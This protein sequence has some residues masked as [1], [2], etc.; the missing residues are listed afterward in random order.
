MLQALDNSLATIFYILTE[1]IKFL[2]LIKILKIFPHYNILQDLIMERK[3]QI[4]S[5]VFTRAE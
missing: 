4:F 2:S 5:S 3:E 1:N